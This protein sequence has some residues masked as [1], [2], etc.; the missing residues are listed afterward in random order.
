MPKLPQDRAEGANNQESGDFQPLKP[1]KYVMRLSEVEE[2]ETGER[3]KNPGTPKWVW[4]LTVD[5][6][7]HPELKKGRW[8][9]SF[10]EHVPLT[11]NMDWKM[12][13]L[14]EGFGY[15]TDSDTDEI[16]E[17]PDARIVGIVKTGKDIVTDEPRS[18]VSRYIVFDS[19]KFTFHGDDADD[20]NQ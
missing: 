9:T 1:G 7:Y 19:S 8:Q 14:F 13:Q 3:S 18:E 11:E 16:L 5:K 10:S 12:K 2:G 6:D 17:D 20:D 4:K 15:S